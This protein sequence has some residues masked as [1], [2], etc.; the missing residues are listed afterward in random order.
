ME[1][2]YV[3]PGLYA[4]SFRVDLP[5]S[6]AYVVQE[7]MKKY[8]VECYIIGLEISD[9][10]KQHFQC[11]LWFQSRINQSKL[12][13]W[14]KGKTADTKQPV[15]LTSAKKIKNL[16]KYTMKD[17]Y[18]KTNLSTEEINNIGKW[19][20]KL[21]KHQ[22]SKKLDEYA[23]YVRDK[24]DGEWVEPLVQVSYDGYA[25]SGSAKVYEFIGILLDF[26]RSNDKRPN[27]STIQYLCWKYK[28]IT[29]N[30]IISKWF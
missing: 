4:Y 23:E 5:H 6:N 21:E 18:F 1:D 2:K 22:W 25:S 15:S 7:F 10:G 28:I 13:N 11:I 14:W 16:A 12:R 19:K 9:L 24:M 29:N 17:N 20:T 3:K 26:Y 30:E 27:R 8:N